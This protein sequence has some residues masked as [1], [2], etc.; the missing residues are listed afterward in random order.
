MNDFRILLNN[1]EIKCNHVFASLTSNKISNQIKEHPN[2]DFID[3]S[4]CRFPELIKKFFGIIKGNKI[5]IHESNFEQIYDTIHFLEFS[6]DSIQSFIQNSSLS[7]TSTDLSQISPASIDSIDHILSSHFFHLRN[8]N[9]L[10]EFIQNAVE[11][12][13][14]YL[15][16][17]RY[18]YFGLV[19]CFH[20][21][22][23][24]NSIRFDEIDHFL[25]EHLR[26]VFFSN[27]LLSFEK[28]FNWQ[29][30]QMLL[31]SENIEE[32]FEEKKKNKEIKF[33]F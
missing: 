32:C 10:L 3:F 25:F 6:S 16:F 23:L 22:Q 33:L 30:N 11:E 27:Y 15:N 13:R 12:N 14:G 7:F 26:C 2:L 21:I 8:E 28:E 4:N 24:I 18:V 19:D 17:L 29:D 5:E 1:D 9:Q 20:L 31:S